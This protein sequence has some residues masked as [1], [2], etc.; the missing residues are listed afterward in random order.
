MVA[1]DR[2]QELLELHETA[3]GAAT[4]D[5]PPAIQK[6]RTVADPFAVPR[7]ALYTSYRRSI[8]DARAAIVAALAV[9]DDAASTPVSRD[10]ASETLL[11]ADAALLAVAAGVKQLQLAVEGAE[12]KM[13][14]RTKLN[15]GRQIIEHNYNALTVLA[16]AIGRQRIA[17]ALARE[18][19]DRHRSMLIRFSKAGVLVCPT[20]ERAYD[21][22]AAAAASPASPNQ[23]ALKRVA[24][25]QPKLGGLNAKVMAGNA[26]QLTKRAVAGVKSLAE[27]TSTGVVALGARASKRADSDPAAAAARAKIHAEQSRWDTAVGELTETERHDLQEEHQQLVE[28][29]RQSS[30]AAARQVEAAVRDLSVLT[31]ILGE[32]VALQAEKLVLVERNTAASKTN[33]EAASG[34]LLK[35]L[36]ARWTA[37]RVL[38]VTLFACSGALLGANWLIR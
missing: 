22:A 35:P 34:E 7:V 37:K 9:I 24:A 18:E 33:L 12:T 4:E 13:A 27:A 17:V 20:S 29:Q 26:T 14:A 23:D 28:M 3:R 21:A 19:V 1:R 36:A 15:E 31:A 8:T 11:M 16:E 30:V 6:A 5:S 2:T 38:A 32:Q 25:K 10:S